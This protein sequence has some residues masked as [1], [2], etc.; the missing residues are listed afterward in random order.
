MFQQNH[1]G[2]YRSDDG[3][4]SWTEISEG[5]P[6]DFG[7]AAATH[8]HDRDTF[9]VIPLDPGHG[10]TMPDG[11]AAVWRTRDAGSS[12]QRLDRG[13]P[14]EN[15]YVGVLRDGMAIDTQDE[16]GLYFGTSTGQ[17]YASTDEG[18]SWSQIG[19]LF[20]GIT[21]VTVASVD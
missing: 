9:Y 11:K 2:M 4:E 7:F 10:R 8:P 6:S 17:L 14:G 16:P 5:L 1:F 13:L 15:A 3:G 18:E 21:S 12:W 19:G 20:P